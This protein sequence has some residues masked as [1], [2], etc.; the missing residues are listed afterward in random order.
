MSKWKLIA[1]ITLVFI[2]GGLVGSIGTRVY[3]KHHILSLLTD[4]KV[5][6]AH[7]MKGLSKAL[8]LTQDQKIKIGKI[9][10]QME[11]QRREFSFNHWPEIEKILN[12]GYLQIRKQLDNDQQK[13]LDA[14]REN[15]E[16]L[17]GSEKQGRGN[18]DSRPG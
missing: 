17:R 10:E 9:I 5:R 16:R 2:V 3:I 14:L 1:G 12:E 18:S 8:N 7:F 4:S 13:K 6:N 15:F 11:Q